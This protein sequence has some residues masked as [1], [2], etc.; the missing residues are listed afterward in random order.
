MPILM[1]SSL[2]SLTSWCLKTTCTEMHLPACHNCCA[3]NPVKHSCPIKNCLC[4]HGIMQ[5]QLSQMSTVINIRRIRRYQHTSVDTVLLCW[6]STVTTAVLHHGA[7]VQ[8]ARVLQGES[9]CCVSRPHYVSLN[10][11]PALLYEAV[12]F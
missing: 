8:Y 5:E 1:T 4:L 10:L 2:N 12:G 7:H 9:R 11:R 3:G 6:V